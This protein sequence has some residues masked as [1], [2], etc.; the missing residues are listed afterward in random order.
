MTGYR[1]EHF[2]HKCGKDGCYIDQLPDWS[3]LIAE[4][5]PRRI[6]PTDIDGMVEINGHLLFLEEKGLGVG[7]D[8]GQRI[9]L[10]RLAQRDGITVVLFRPAPPERPWD[11]EVL[12]YGEG[13]PQGW[14]PRTREQFKD[15]LRDWCAAAEVAAPD[16]EAAVVRL[17]SALKRAG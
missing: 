16:V 11:L 7:P 4:C 2:R 8:N 1:S 17:D 13:E 5:F 9:A 15:W 12:I 3:D 6:R 14:Q 10:R